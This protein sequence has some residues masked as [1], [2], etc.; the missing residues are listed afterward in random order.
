MMPAVGQFLG[1]KRSRCGHEGWWRKVEV[2][3]AGGR[4]A[5]AWVARQFGGR[6][7]ITR[8]WQHR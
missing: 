5:E 6:G 3:I 2:K 1:M 8:C 4:E 7:V